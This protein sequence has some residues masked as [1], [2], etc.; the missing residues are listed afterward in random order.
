M[1]TLELGLKGAFAGIAGD[2]E[3]IAVRI[4][5]EHVTG[6]WYI[7]AIGEASDLLV[8]NAIEECAVVLENGHA[9]A[10]EVA[11]VKIVVWWA[12]AQWKTTV[13]N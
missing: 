6:I 10:F 11:H 3:A 7:N 13:L 5:D 2:V 4:T 12:R 8:A 9:M 1:G